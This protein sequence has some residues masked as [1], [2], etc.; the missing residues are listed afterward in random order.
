[1]EMSLKRL[2]QAMEAIQKS[3]KIHKSDIQTWLSAALTFQETCRDTINDHASADSYAA[4][5]YNK[6]DHLSKLASNSLALANRIT[7]KGRRLLQGGDFPAWVSAA[8]RKLLQSDAVKANAVVAKDGS[9]D[10]KS[11]G[12]AIN[13]AGGGRYVIYVKAG[14]YNEKISTNK[15]GITLIGDGKYA[16]IITAGTSV[17]KGASLKG[18]ATFSTF[19][20]SLFLSFSVFLNQGSP[21][22][23]SMILSVFRQSL[24][25]FY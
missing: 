4:E 25:W 20:V 22:P 5:I 12:E 10:F 13:A 7:R 14:T 8:D 23:I 18:S 2:N 21:M 15:D 3:P 1:M 9:G 19:S 6:I 17:G 11:V 24:S 16:T